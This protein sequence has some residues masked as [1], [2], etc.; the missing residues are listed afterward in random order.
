MVFWTLLFFLLM[1]NNLLIPGDGGGTG[2]DRKFPALRCRKTGGWTKG[3][4][5]EPEV[6]HIHDL[7][8]ETGNLLSARLTSN[9]WR[10]GVAALICAPSSTGP[11]FSYG[12]QFHAHFKT[13][14]KPMMNKYYVSS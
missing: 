14:V 5:T 3:L 1:L 10:Q 13:F 11:I 4:A 2:V 6:L 12:L 9:T 7:L 8:Q